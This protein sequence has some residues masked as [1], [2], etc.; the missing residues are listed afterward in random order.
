MLKP[1]AIQRTICGEV[2]SRIEKKGFKIVAMKFLK[3]PKELAEELYKEHK[4]KGFYEGLVKY[5]TSSP[6][7]AMIV[8]GENAVFVIRTMMG[9]TN[10]K[11]ALNGTIRGDFGLTT[12]KN[13]IHGSDSLESAKREIALFFKE[14]EIFEYERIDEKWVYE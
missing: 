14:N 13:V 1:D 5:I 11:E 12:A 6:V 2:I 3:I 10:P 9:K 4:G 8:E 7:I